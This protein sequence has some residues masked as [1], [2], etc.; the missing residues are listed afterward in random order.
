MHLIRHSFSWMNRTCFIGICW[1]SMHAPAWSRNLGMIT[2]TLQGD[3]PDRY[4]QARK[5]VNLPL[6]CPLR[7]VLLGRSQDF[8][9]W[10]GVARCREKLHPNCNSSS[11]LDKPCKRK[12]NRCR[13]NLWEFL[14]FR[15]FH[16]VSL[17]LCTQWTSVRSHGVLSVVFAPCW[18]MSQY[19]SLT[20]RYTSVPSVHKRR[21]WGL[22]ALGN[23]ILSKS[24]GNGAGQLATSR[25]KPIWWY[26]QSNV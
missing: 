13:K 14:G 20:P 24:S 17:L 21:R 19:P 9:A 22:A 8:V 5:F 26:R 25:P 12:W 18:L 16:Y 2:A 11:L 3:V 10:L 23:C 4:F 6:R 7:F 1:L 15:G